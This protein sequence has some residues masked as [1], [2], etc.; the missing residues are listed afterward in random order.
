M[1]EAGV[2]AKDAGKWMRMLAL[3]GLAVGLI[4]TGPLRAQEKDGAGVVVGK[5]V[6][7]KDIGLKIYPG[8]TPVKETQ[9]DSSAN[10]SAWLGGSGFQLTVLK[11]ETKDAPDKVAAFYRKELGRY[12]K[13]LDCSNAKKPA[14]AKSDEDSN[15]LTCDDNEPA[16]NAYVYK[17]GTKEKQHVVSVEPSGSGTKYDLVYVAGWKAEK[18]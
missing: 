4:A 1:G 7:A 16:P 11:L 17:A 14:K 9:N 15:E 2:C 18:K 3:V 10:F 12:G 5:D 8:S 6:K 13:V